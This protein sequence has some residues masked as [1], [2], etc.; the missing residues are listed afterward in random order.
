MERTADSLEPDR[1]R[2]VGTVTHLRRR[3]RRVSVALVTLVL[4]SSAV[5]VAAQTTDDLF[6]PST[7]NDL[8]LWIN[9]RDLDQLRLTYTENTYYQADME[10]GGMRVRNA[11]VRSRGNA[12]RN[13]H[14][15]GLRVD[16]NRY[17]TGQRFL[18]LTSL[19]LDNLVQDPGFIREGAVMSMFARMGLAAPREAYVRLFINGAFEGVYAVV[20]PMD[21]DFLE[22]TTGDRGGYLFDYEWVHPFHTEY[23]GEDLEPYKARFKP[24][25]KQSAG[26]VTLYAP[27]HDLFAEINRPD[28]GAWREHVEQLLDVPHF[29]MHVAVE[30]FVS[31]A[32]GLMGNW[33]MNNFYL[34]RPGDSTRHQILPWDRDGSFQVI[35]SSIMLR[36]A[37]HHLFQRLI[38]YDDLR[39][40]YLQA[41]EACARAAAEGDWLEN[42]LATRAA[43]V[44]EAVASDTHKPYTVDD[45]EAHVAFLQAFARLR[46]GIVLAEVN[47]LRSPDVSRGAGPS[48]D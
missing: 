9:A 25:T 37:E 13:P 46:P 5:S 47:Q 18:G 42:L 21:A 27:I 22:R 36:T 2:P 48:A 15:P 6:D 20:E 39:E 10:W 30:Q 19:I 28:D 4:S 44:R 31:E 34:Y 24:E 43:L 11:A 29:L 1:A 35:D 38:A 3:L 7:V 33:A 8:H 17:A 32:D 26:D 16:F 14:K 23:L 41:I 12:T 45:F 40:T